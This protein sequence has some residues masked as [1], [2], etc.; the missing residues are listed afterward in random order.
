MRFKKTLLTILVLCMTFALTGCAFTPTSRRDIKKHVREMLGHRDFKVSKN[1]ERIN[2]NDYSW[3]VY[4]K[5]NDIHFHVYDEYYS[6]A[7]LF[8]TFGREV[9]DDYDRCLIEKYKDEISDTVEYVIS[10][11]DEEESSYNDYDDSEDYSDEDEYQDD[12]DDKLDKRERYFLVSYDDMDSLEKGCEDLW[13]FY[14]KLNALH[15]NFQIKYVLKFDYSDLEE[16]YEDVGFEYDLLSQ[17]GYLGKDR[18][19]DR[20]GAFSPEEMSAEAKAGY[21][22]FGITYQ[23]PEIIDG[24][25]EDE[26]AQALEESIYYRVGVIKDGESTDYSNEIYSNDDDK[27][28]FGNLYWLL[29][30]QGGNI[31]GSPVDFE[32]IDDNGDKYQFAYTNCVD[33]EGAY[34]LKN[35]ENVYINTEYDTY[36]WA[37]IVEKSVI[38][39]V[40]GIDT[41]FKVKDKFHHVD[42]DKDYFSV[43]DSGKLDTSEYYPFEREVKSYLKDNC[44]EKVKYLGCQFL[45]HS[46]EEV[47]YSFKTKERGLVFNVYRRQITDENDKKK[48][49]F[50]SDYANKVRELYRDDIETLFDEFDYPFNEGVLLT[51][52]EQAQK[53]IAAVD[54]A[55]EIYR[56]ELKYNSKEF[57]MNHPI[58]QVDVWGCETDDIHNDSCYKLSEYVIYGAKIDKEAR[59]EELENSIAAAIKDGNLSKEIYT[60]LSDK[61]DSFHKSQLNHIYLNDEEMLYDNNKS[62]YSYYGL[63]T[64]D[65]CY[66]YYDEENEQYMM[67]IDFGLIA[68]YCGSVPLV[69]AEY[70]DRL[71]GTFT[72]LTPDQKERTLDLKT[73]WEYGGHTWNMSSHYEDQGVSKVKFT[74]DGQKLDIDVQEGKAFY[75]LGV[76][77]DDF[78]KLFDFTY[79]IDEDADSIYFYTK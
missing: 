77:V 14:D 62:Q 6:E 36:R 37:P 42:L 28:S 24:L 75:V 39:E 70:M 26:K 48:I 47:R 51:N 10:G 63:V 7:D 13:N 76:S 46:P 11:E 49:E 54:K 16:K 41:Y 59:L 57:L 44:G 4:D 66:S 32:Y 20:F 79:K 71:G 65:Y 23:L 56:K 9:W 35:D 19:Y 73:Q 38:S 29:K 33:Y 69:I 18:T 61:I 74:K 72:I 60:G 40:F 43:S 3:E 52:T 78:C 25:S 34:Y 67:S 8:I 68:D 55:N 31:S 30:Y 15:Y 58:G 50:E 5:K 45:C 2:N 64:D 27:L 1:S 21:Y 12:S 53:V 17:S 22:W